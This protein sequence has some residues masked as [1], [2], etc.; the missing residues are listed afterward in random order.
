MILPSRFELAALGLPKSRARY[1]RVLGMVCCMARASNGVMGM[2]R[3][4]QTVGRNH[5]CTTITLRR[6]GLGSRPDTFSG[7][8]GIDVPAA[9]NRYVKW[10]KALSRRKSR[11]RGEERVEKAECQDRDMQQ[12]PS[13]AGVDVMTTTAPFRGRHWQGSVKHPVLGDPLMYGFTLMLGMC[14]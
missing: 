12:K 4:G 11:E 8:R 13:A 6:C 5:L 3:L 2:G 14:Q 10:Q 7:R 9:A 1:R